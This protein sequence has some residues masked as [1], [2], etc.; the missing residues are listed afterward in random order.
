MRQ[1][2]VHVLQTDERDDASSDVLRRFWARAKPLPA[3]FESRPDARV[4]D[5]AAWAQ[6]RH[7]VAR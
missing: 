2:L 4:I 6:S 5:L 1:R 7:D 3:R